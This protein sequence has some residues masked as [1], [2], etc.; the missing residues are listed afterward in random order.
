VMRVVSDVPQLPTLHLDGL[1][2]G[3]HLALMSPVCRSRPPA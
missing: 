1:V 2:C 3:K